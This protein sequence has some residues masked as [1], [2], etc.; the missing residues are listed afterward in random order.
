MEEGIGNA[1]NTLSSAVRLAGDSQD[2]L[3][4]PSNG[5][6]VRCRLPHLSVPTAFEAVLRTAQVT[7]PIV[8]RR[9]LPCAQ[10]VDSDD[11]LRRQ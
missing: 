8:F 10:Y 11:E 6:T 4:L 5:G 1:P 2:F 3:S 9:K 7:V